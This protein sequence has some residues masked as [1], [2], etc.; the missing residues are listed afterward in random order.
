MANRIDT[1]HDLQTARTAA[2]QALR[3]AADQLSSADGWSHADGVYF[4]VYNGEGVSLDLSLHLHSGQL[5]IASRPTLGLAQ[6]HSS[7]QIASQSR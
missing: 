1:G 6:P 3:L 4:Q 5:W 7:D 2:A